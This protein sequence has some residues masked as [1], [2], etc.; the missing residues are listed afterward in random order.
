METTMQKYN[1]PQKHVP[2]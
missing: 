2:Y 1:Y